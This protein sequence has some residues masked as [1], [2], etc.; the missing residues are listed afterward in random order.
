MSGRSALDDDQ[1]INIEANIPSNLRHRAVININSSGVNADAIIPTGPD[2]E[3]R[4]V[5]RPDGTLIANN[6][7]DF[8]DASENL[9]NGI[10]AGLAPGD[11]YWTGMDITAGSFGGSPQHCNNWRNTTGNGRRGVASVVTNR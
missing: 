2:R 6:W 3:F 9:R 7:R 11:P 8:F 1:R 4:T 10:E 5:R